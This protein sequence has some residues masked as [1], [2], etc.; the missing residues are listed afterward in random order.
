MKRN[1]GKYRVVEKLP[2]GAMTVKQYADQ[3][4]INQATPYLQWK[5]GNA[6]FE[7]IIF[8]GINFIIPKKKKTVKEKIIVQ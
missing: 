5:R 8:V 1:A 3:K 7:I 4:G 2:K 6:D